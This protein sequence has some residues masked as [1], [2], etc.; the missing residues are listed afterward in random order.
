MKMR[1][2]K[3]VILKTRSAF[4]LV[5]LLL[6]W[7]STAEPVA[8]PQWINLSISPSAISFPAADPDDQPVVRASNQVSLTIS[9]PQSRNWVLYIRA[10]G[11][12]SSAQ[13]VTIPI[14]NVSWVA[15]PKP[16]LLDGI[17]VA[18]KNIQLGSGQGRLY[19]GVLTFSFNNSWNYC[20]G[21]YNQ[22][23]TFTA[24]QL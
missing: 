7:V 6:L 22:I 9:L 21:T 4:F 1:K 24:T 15:S 2:K 17:L 3:R 13:G 10:E 12:L 16:P 19:N 23:I 18:G 14:S 11:D 8:R 5:V 20:A